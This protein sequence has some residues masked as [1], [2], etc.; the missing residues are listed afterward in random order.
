MSYLVSHCLVRYHEYLRCRREQRTIKTGHF[1]RPLTF[2]VSRFTQR[3]KGG[4]RNRRGY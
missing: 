2:Y 4:D 1:Q 3:R